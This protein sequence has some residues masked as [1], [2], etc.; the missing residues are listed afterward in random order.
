MLIRERILLQ[1]LRAAG[2]AV[3]RVEL[4]KWA[5]LLRQDRAGVIGD[6]FYEFFPH[7]R[8]PYSFV[9]RREMDRLVADGIVSTEGETWEWIRSE[10]A[11]GLPAE[12]ARS[13]A[14]VCHRYREMAEGELLSDVYQ[15]FPDF[16]MCSDTRPLAGRATGTIQVHTC[17]YEGVSIDGFLRLLIC[18]GLR[19][20]VDV[21]RNPVARRYGFHK[22]T[23]AHLC[24]EVGIE[25]QHLPELG[26]ASE[27]RSGD[28]AFA[29][30]GDLLAWYEREHLPTVPGAVRE[31]ADSVAH[32]PT[33][34]MCRE[35][36]PCECHRSRLAQRVA[37][38]TGLPVAHLRPSS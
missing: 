6:S 35:A 32:R 19:R 38:L 15:R 2:R 25:Y 33:A 20:L 27:H 16:T 21:R 36:N 13:V 28:S 5:F 31:V 37:D 7:R 17:G 11:S 18:S 3:S 29:S 1:L 4:V 10:S 14:S 34:V 12:D 24:G 22:S 26:I 23:L 8:G 30:R 9:L